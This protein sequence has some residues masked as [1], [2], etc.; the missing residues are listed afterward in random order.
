MTVLRTALLK[1]IEQLRERY[2]CQ[3]GQQ[4]LFVPDADHCDCGALRRPAVEVAEACLFTPAYDTPPPDGEIQRRCWSLYVNVHGNGQCEL[5]N[6]H[7]GGHRS[8]E[9]VW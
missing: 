6:G 4:H 7:T 1:P 3:P 5:F 9:A 2:G 8:G